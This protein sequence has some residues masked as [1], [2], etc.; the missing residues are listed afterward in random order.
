MGTGGTC[1]WVIQRQRL[2]RLPMCIW[3][4]ESTSFLGSYPPYFWFINSSFV[5]PFSKFLK[6]KKSKKQSKWR[7]SNKFIENNNKFRI[8]YLTI[9]SMVP[10]RHSGGN[11]D[12]WKYGLGTQQRIRILG[13][14]L[15]GM[16]VQAKVSDSRETRQQS[17]GWDCGKYLHL[18]RGEGISELPFAHHG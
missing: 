12:C 2:K 4:C 13:R 16:S 15:R 8:Y 5:C 3:G 7:V 11:V 17:Q 18:R 6:K 1:K 14:D 9:E 10:I